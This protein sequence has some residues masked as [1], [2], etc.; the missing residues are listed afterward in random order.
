MSGLSYH[1]GKVA[2]G[3]PCRGFESLSLRQKLVSSGITAY[4][5]IYLPCQ[6]VANFSLAGH[7]FLGAR[8]CLSNGNY[9]TNRH[10]PQSQ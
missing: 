4:L 5:S 9:K 3:Q 6:R 7:S 2:Q 8:S 10:M 1:P